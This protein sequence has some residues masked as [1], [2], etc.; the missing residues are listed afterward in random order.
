MGEGGPV[1]NVPV[2]TPPPPRA[3]KVLFGGGVVMLQ[4]STHLHP[5]QKIAQW[6]D[7]T[8]VSNQRVSVTPRT[9][10]PCR[11]SDMLK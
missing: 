11:A 5:R 4:Q 9:Y 6:S 10:L 2:K 1:A 7:D 8:F 3:Y